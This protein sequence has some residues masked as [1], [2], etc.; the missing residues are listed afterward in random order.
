[1]RS[2]LPL[3][4]LLLAGCTTRPATNPDELGASQAVKARYWE[5]Q[6]R[7]RSAPERT[8]QLVL[9]ERVEDGTLRVPTIIELPLP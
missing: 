8:I 3:S 6:A 5:I 2:L 9:P 7:Q 1:M 4:I